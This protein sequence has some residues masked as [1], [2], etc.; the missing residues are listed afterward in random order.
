MN[1]ELKPSEKITLYDRIA[2]GF[3][4]GVLA[5]ITYVFLWSIFALFAYGHILP[6][7]IFYLFIGGIF[8]LGFFTLDNYFIEI[9]TSL[10][11]FIIRA[12]G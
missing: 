7:E 8:L 2:V 4:S 5:A 1:Q 9:L 12:F 11:R 3:V 10:W 6:I